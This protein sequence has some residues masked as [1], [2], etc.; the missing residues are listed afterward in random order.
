MFA[1]FKLKGRV[2]IIGRAYVVKRP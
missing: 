1:L 2:I